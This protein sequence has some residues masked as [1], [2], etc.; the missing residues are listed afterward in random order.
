MSASAA[1]ATLSDS[2]TRTEAA[3][4]GATSAH[5]RVKVLDAELH[6]AFD[7]LEHAQARLRDEGAAVTVQMSAPLAAAWSV[8]KQGN[9]TVTLIGGG[10][11]A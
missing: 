4:R 7:A 5:E 1:R 8:W 9:K 3:Y 6:Q 2:V 11:D 10:P